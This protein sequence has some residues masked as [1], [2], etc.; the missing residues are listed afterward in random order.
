MLVR[1][2]YVCVYVYG[3]GVMVG[4]VDTVMRAWQVLQA[5]ASTN[6]KGAAAWNGS[7]LSHLTRV[8]GPFW[9]SPDR[10]WSRIQ[11]VRFATRIAVVT[12]N[13]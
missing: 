12:G 5:R 10:P 1:Q 3:D 6:P 8:S 7:R 11:P 2:R 9:F 4:M 13:L